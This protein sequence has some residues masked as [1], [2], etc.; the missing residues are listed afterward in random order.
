MRRR[1]HTGFPGGSGQAPGRSAIRF[2][3][4]EFY[5]VTDAAMWQGRKAHRHWRLPGPVIH[6]RAPFS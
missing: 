3:I 6:L 5:A 4:P 1:G 2:V